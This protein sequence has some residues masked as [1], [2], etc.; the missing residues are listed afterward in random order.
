MFVFEATSSANY[1]CFQIRRVLKAKSGVLEHQK[2][3][4]QRVSAATQPGP[5][6]SR[7][8]FRITGLGLG[9]ES[10]SECSNLSAA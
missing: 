2:H 1:S 3:C 10:L 6:G 5:R 4:K 8:G 9:F 7:S